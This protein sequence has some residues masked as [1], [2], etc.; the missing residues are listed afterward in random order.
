MRLYYRL[1]EEIYS[2]DEGREKVGSDATLE[3]GGH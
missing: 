2:E 3:R 1:I